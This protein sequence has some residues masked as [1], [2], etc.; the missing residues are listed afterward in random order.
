MFTY[1]YVSTFQPGDLT[2]WCSEEVWTV[3]DSGKP[4]AEGEGGG[5]GRLLYRTEIGERGWGGG[6]GG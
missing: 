5:G 4:G 6:G 2:G 1:V 3:E